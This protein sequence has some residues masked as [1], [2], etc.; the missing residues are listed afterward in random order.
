M[1]KIISPI[2]GKQ[3]YLLIENCEFVSNTKISKELKESLQLSNGKGGTLNIQPK[4][5]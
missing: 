2:T 1:K 4:Y 3:K 5:Y